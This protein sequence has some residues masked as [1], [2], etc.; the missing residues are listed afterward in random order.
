VFPPKSTLLFNMKY[1]LS[2]MVRENAIGLLTTRRADA[3]DFHTHAKYTHWS[4]KG[5][6]RSVT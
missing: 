4:V 5:L 3:V 2:P 1:D 6:E